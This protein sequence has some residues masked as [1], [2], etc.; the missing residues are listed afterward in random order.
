MGL[1]TDSGAGVVTVATRC[2]KFFSCEAVPA[3]SD[4]KINRATINVNLIKAH[5]IAS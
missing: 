1:G 4:E 2:E 3:I 5:L